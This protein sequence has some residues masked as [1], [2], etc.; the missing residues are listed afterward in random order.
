SSA[1]VITIYHTLCLHD[2]LPIFLQ[3][4]RVPGVEEARLD[5]GVQGVEGAGGAQPGDLVGVLELE[6]LRDPLD[7]GETAGAE[8]GVQAAIDRSEEHTSE[9][10]SR[11]NLVCRLLL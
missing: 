10:Q 11:E 6:Q 2:A 1:V 3:H 8:L 7:V 4:G 9:L 5:R